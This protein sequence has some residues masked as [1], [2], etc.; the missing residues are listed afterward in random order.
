MAGRASRG[1]RSAGPA[2][3]QYG[4]VPLRHCGTQLGFIGV[5][6]THLWAP[7]GPGSV[8][9]LERAE[10]TEF[11]DLHIGKAD[12]P[13]HVSGVLSEPGSRCSAPLLVVVAEA[14]RTPDE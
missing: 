11:V 4:D 9:E 6:R 1:L 5:R 2:D 10:L 14:H 13:Q 8:R 12:L 3:Q 7:G